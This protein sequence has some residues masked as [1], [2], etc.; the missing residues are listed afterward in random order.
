MSLHVKNISNSNLLTLTS[1]IPSKDNFN[2][3]I[4]GREQLHFFLNTIHLFV[5]TKIFGSFSHGTSRLK[6]MLPKM[7]IYKRRYKH[8]NY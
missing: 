4:K 1:K 2:I 8:R 7:V 6:Y 3:K 5:I